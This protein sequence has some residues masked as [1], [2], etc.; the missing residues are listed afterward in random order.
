MRGLAPILLAGL[1]TLPSVLAQSGAEIRGTTLDAR[2]GQALTMVDVRLRGRAYTTRSDANGH[3]TITRL[4]PGNYL[5]QASTVGYRMIT[6]E[7]HLDNDEGR[8]FE[9]VLSPDGFNRVDSVTVHSGSIFDAAGDPVANPFRL[10]GNDLKNLGT[11]LADDPLRAVQAVPGVSSN[12][13]FEARFSLR[14]AGFNRIG[15]YLDGIQLHH[16]VHTLE[17]TAT[18][19]SNSL[20]NTDLI[21]EVNLYAGAYPSRFGD[22]SAGVLNVRMRDGNRNDYSFRAMANFADAGLMAEGPLGKIDG[23][24][25]ISGFRKSYLQ[26]LLQQTLSDTPMAFGF[27][28]V[29]VRL[30]CK[31]SPASLVTLDLIEGD[32][33]LDRTSVRQTLGANSLMLAHQRSKFVNLG[34]QYAVSD[35]LLFTNHFAWTQESYADSNSTPSPLGSGRYREWTW[36]G[37]GTWMWNA[38]N[39]LEIGGGLRSIGQSGYLEQY[40]SPTV[41][42]VL[43]KYK[44]TGTLASGFVE[45][46]WTT[47]GG[48]LHLTAG[49]RWDRHSIDAVST[50]SPQA[51][52]TIGLWPSAQFQLGWGQYVQ[53][54]EISEF[55]SNLGSRMLLPIR[56]THATVAVEQRVGARTRLRATFYNRQDRDLLYQPFLDPRLVNG[57]VF[58]PP[59]NPSYQNSLRG[60]GRGF[61]FFA[62]RNSANGFDGWL[63]YAYGRAW[64]H[65]GV[66]GDSFPSDYDQ[67]HTINGYVSYRIRPTINVSTRWTYG[68]GFPVRAFVSMKEPYSY[69]WADVYALGDQRN[70]LRIGPYQRLDLRVNKSWTRAKWK[71]TLYGEVANVTNRANYR[72][73]NFEAYDAKNKLAY[74]TLDRLFPILPSVGIVFER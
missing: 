59:A 30:S 20:F 45:Q 62:Q 29:Q 70:R 44:G 57:T 73:D 63:S 60:Y 39:P 35:E 6:T 32:T 36:N 46:A 3:F 42:Q 58:V 14:G 55:T 52:M 38:K 54:P 67:R 12:D 23:C 56:S 8:D 28:D 5:L 21:E 69:S 61:E 66:T 41:I 18:S 68:S 48:R 26:Y 34:W 65:D 40:N 9:L 13:D 72:F 2:T 74:I 16:V 22:S 47:A 50:L 37:S 11:V 24:S 17:G 33:N 51:G 64:M 25:W 53:F 7:F 4:P 71:A 15:V 43:D 27:Q 49:G 19:G 10:A 31:V 1:V